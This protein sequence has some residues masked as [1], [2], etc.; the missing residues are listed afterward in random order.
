MGSSHT[1]LLFHTGVHWLSRGKILNQLFELGLELQHF[2]NDRFELRIFLHDWKWL[3]KLKY[4]AGIFYVENCLN[5]LLQGKEISLFHIHEKKN[6]AI[7]KL[8]L[9][10]KRVGNGDVDSFPSPS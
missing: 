5:L 6:A 1:R 10:Q 7:A 9:W 4:S 2:L 3:C 8:N